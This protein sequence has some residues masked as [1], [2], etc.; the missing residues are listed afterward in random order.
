LPGDLDL[1]RQEPPVGFARDAGAHD[2]A[3][4]TQRFGEVDAPDLRQ[5]GRLALDAELV[6]RNVKTVAAA[7]LAFETRRVGRRARL[8]GA[9]VAGEGPGQMREGLGVGVAV[10]RAQ[11]GLAILVLPVGMGILDGVELLFEGHRVRALAGRRLALPFGER[12][13]PDPAGGAGRAREI[14]ALGGGGFDA[15]AVGQEHGK[16]GVCIA[17]FDP[18][19]RTGFAGNARRFV[20]EQG[21]LHTFD[22]EP[23]Y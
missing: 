2:L 19:R 23:R 15:D 7:A 1:H 13:V 20:P 12:P 3:R 10:D 16:A 17:G 4:K 8:D 11:P 21:R 9:E 6:V 18:S 14:A 5:H 22:H